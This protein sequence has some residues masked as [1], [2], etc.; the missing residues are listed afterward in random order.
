VKTNRPQT[1]QKRGYDNRRRALKAAETAERIR[2][3]AWRLFSTRPYDEVT[4]AEVA[5]LAG[6][7]ARTVIGHYGGKEALFLAGFRAWGEA[8][9]NRRREIDPDDPT[10]PLKGL[11]AD[12]ERDGDVGLHLMSEERRFPAVKQMTDRGRRY[13]RNWVREV[14]ARHLQTLNGEALERRH[15]QLVVAT[16]LLTWKLLRSDMG[17][18]RKRAE[19]SVLEM[20]ETLTGGP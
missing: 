3:E 14:F 17:L 19:A 11:I 20:I 2:E 7:T 15:T 8:A 1:R 6:V 4:I 16:D 18:S 9:A 13:H 12:Y 5:E 10:K